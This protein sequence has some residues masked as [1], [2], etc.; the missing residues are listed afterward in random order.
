MI[1]ILKNMILII[2]IL[3]LKK[4]DFDFENH[5]IDFENHDIDFEKHV[6]EIKIMPNSDHIDLTYLTEPN[7]YTEETFPPFRIC[8]LF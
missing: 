8:F 4:H 2:M 7:P 3:I 1:L 6:F 5:D